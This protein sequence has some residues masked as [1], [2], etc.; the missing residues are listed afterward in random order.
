MPP[1]QQGL[2]R[3]IPVRANA[4]LAFAAFRLYPGAGSYVPLAVD[5]ISLS[6]SGICSVVAFRNPNQLKLF[7][8]PERLP[9]AA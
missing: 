9:L 7:D 2:L 6:H 1:R 4:Q 5:V 8:L 3:L